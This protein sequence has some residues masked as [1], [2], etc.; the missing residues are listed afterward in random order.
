MSKKSIEFTDI[1]GKKYCINI[2]SIYSLC[3]YNNQVTI[4][5]FDKKGMADFISATVSE[6]DIEKVSEFENSQAVYF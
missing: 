5:Y 6:S 1:N 2:S 3:L 4:I